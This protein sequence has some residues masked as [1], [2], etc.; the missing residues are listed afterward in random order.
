M[1]EVSG[2]DMVREIIGQIN[3]LRRLVTINGK[4]YKWDGKKYVRAVDGKTFTKKELVSFVKDEKF[5]APKV[6]DSKK[7]ER[8][9]SLKTKITD[10]AKSVGRNIKNTKP[11][12]NKDVI[13]RPLANLKLRIGKPNQA[14]LN[15]KGTNPTNITNRALQISKSLNPR[16]TAGGLKA[17]GGGLLQGAKGYGI[18]STLDWAAQSLLDRGMRNIEGKQKMSIDDYRALKDKR[19]KD[20]QSKAT[21]WGGVKKNPNMGTNLQ[22][23]PTVTRNRR[24]RV[25][26]TQQPVGRNW[27][28]P[29]MGPPQPKISYEPEKVVTPPNQGTD[30]TKKESVDKVKIKKVKFNPNVPDMGYNTKKTQKKKSKKK[31][32]LK[33]HGKNPSSIQK[34]LL[35]AGFTKKQIEDLVTAY[36]KK[37]RDKRGW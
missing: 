13:N 36:N 22:I 5:E 30:S 29:E 4:K 24:G 6:P 18:G 20:L 15:P 19:F 14:N 23:Q 27:Q 26:D 10:K 11:Q 16:F 8:N 32:E 33:I 12:Y 21:W 1:A 31:D 3:N 2:L 25:I 35:K 28:N 17:L 9:K 37:Y 7:L 34:K